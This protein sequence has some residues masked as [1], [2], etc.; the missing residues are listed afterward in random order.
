VLISKWK[1]LD[2]DVQIFDTIA[3]A[4]RVRGGGVSSLQTD[5]ECNRDFSSTDPLTLVNRLIWQNRQHIRLSGIVAENGTE[6]DVKSRLVLAQA[7]F[8]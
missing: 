3:D 7:D 2:S 4:G 1:T 5:G 6:M 8:N